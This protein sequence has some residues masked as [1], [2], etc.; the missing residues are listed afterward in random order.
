MGRAFPYDNRRRLPR[1]SYATSADCWCRAR[2]DNP[3]TSSVLPER[4]G[5]LAAQTALEASNGRSNTVAAVTAGA[6]FGSAT[7]FL[8]RFV[9]IRKTARGLSELR[10]CL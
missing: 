8:P 1:L 6:G 4:D 3:C 9:V 7:G 5:V 2:C 10:P